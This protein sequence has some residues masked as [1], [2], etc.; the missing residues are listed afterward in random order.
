MR[1]RAR[2]LSLSLS[3]MSAHRVLKHEACFRSGGRDVWPRDVWSR[4]RPQA[5]GP[6]HTQRD[7]EV[8]GV[9]GGASRGRGAQGP[10]GAGGAGGGAGGL[11][12][13]EEGRGGDGCVGGGKGGGGLRAQVA[14]QWGRLAAS[15]VFARRFDRE[16]VSMAVP[17]YTAVMLDPVS[18]LG[19]KV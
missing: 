17:S 8:G 6:L 12:T 1:A 3:A 18:G 7:S 16:I 9:A 4:L 13:E 11:N 5:H 10:G 15:A 14:R 19:F 2:S